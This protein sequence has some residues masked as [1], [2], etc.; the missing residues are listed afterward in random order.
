MSGTASPAHAAGQGAVPTTRAR[1]PVRSN[2]TGSSATVA[3][4]PP[5]TATA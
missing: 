1:S 2:P 4:P 3:S 5:R